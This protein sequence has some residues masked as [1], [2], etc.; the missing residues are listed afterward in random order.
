MFQMASTRI[1]KQSIKKL[2]LSLLMHAYGD[3]TT[4]RSFAIR[5]LT[6]RALTNKKTKHKQNGQP[7]TLIHNNFD[8]ADE[9]GLVFF[10]EHFLIYSATYG[11]K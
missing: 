5:A 7:F 10:K 1:K 9:Y 3:Q 11:F 2:H 4:T 8:M 6:I